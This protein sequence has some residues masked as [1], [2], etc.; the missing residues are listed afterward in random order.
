MEIETITQKIE[1]S[2]K[3]A[4]SSL[5][6]ILLRRRSKFSVIDGGNNSLSNHV[7]AIGVNIAS[8]GYVISPELAKSL[9][10]LS[11]EDLSNVNNSLV[12]SLSDMVGANV[13]YNP[14]F[15]N[16]RK[17]FYRNWRQKRTE[18]QSA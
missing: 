10:T 16:F 18:H 1:V 12:K 17:D 3:T 13:K 8:L 4:T 7:K 9:K 14:L 2:P 5:N 6:D 11:V 15:R